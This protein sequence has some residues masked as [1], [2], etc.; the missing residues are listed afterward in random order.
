[1]APDYK[2]CTAAYCAYLNVDYK[3]AWR[4][5]W[6]LHPKDEARGMQVP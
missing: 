5:L 4:F 1:M 3:G 2:L 6:H